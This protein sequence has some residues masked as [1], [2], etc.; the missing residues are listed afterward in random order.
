MITNMNPMVLIRK[1]PPK[2]ARSCQPPVRQSFQKWQALFQVSS[3]SNKTP[4]RILCGATP[5]AHHITSSQ[6]VFNFQY[7]VE[8]N[9]NKTVSFTCENIT[10]NVSRH[11][12]LKKLNKERRENG[13]DILIYLYGKRITPSLKA[14]HVYIDKRYLRVYHSCESD[15]SRAPL[16]KNVGT[17]YVWYI[18]C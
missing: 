5:P 11:F 16:T 2:L 17:S 14:W 13:V 10:F 7:I 8:I 12:E 18:T 6:R 4:K 3:R 1:I 9:Y 15:V